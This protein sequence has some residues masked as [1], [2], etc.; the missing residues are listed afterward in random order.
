MKDRVV[1]GLVED[2]A[3]DYNI[4]NLKES[5]QFEHLVNFCILSGEKDEDFDSIS[6]SGKKATMA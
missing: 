5:E 1:E 2:F 3:A 6:M 4:S